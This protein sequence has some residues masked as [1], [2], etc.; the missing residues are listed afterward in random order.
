MDTI[1]Q[2]N[3][4]VGR[5]QENSEDD[6]FTTDNALREIGAYAL[7]AFYRSLEKSGLAHLRGTYEAWQK[8]FPEVRKY[9]RP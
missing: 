9:I 1:L 8:I 3:G 7:D 2:L 5:G 6:V 4:G